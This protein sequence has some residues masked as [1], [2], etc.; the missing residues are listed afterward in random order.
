MHPITRRGFMGLSASAAT[1]AGLAACGSSSSS[2]GPGPDSAYTPP[3]K[4]LTAE[5]RYAIWDASQVDSMKKV[6]QAFNKTYPKITVNVEVTPFDHYW[7]K[8]QTE[9]SSGTTPDI[10]WMNPLSFELYAS[11]K[12]LMPT[13]PLAD[14]GV[15]KQDDYPPPAWDMYNYDKVH[16]GV[17]KDNDAIAI[18]YNKSIFS[19]YDIA[20]PKDAWTWDDLTAKLEEIKNKSKGKV[21]GMTGPVDA[22]GNHSWYNAIYQAGG[23]VLSEDKK[24]CG[25]DQP[26]AVEGVKFWAEMISNKYVPSIK[27]LTDTAWASWFTSGRAAMACAGSW[28]LNTFYEAL[29]KDLEV[30]PWASG[31]KGN[32]TCVSAS[33]NMMPA[34]PNPKN[35]A[36]SLAF[37]QFFGGKEAALIQAKGHIVIPAFTDGQAPWFESAPGVDHLSIFKQA[38][39]SGFQ[40]PHTLNTAAWQKVELEGLLPVFQGNKDAQSACSAVAPKINDLLAKE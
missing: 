14:A 1:V 26:Q 11:G 33:N 38:I 22:H 2:G 12:K 30:A 9:A 18:W 27:Q 4:D 19:Q 29:G 3:P 36:A 7:T 23:H 20:P 24:T 21:F 28:Q 34:K 17:P 31:S 8:L 13:K 35:E 32:P 25:Y 15:I 6:V 16:Y 39:Q 40:N 5:L 10:F 37:L